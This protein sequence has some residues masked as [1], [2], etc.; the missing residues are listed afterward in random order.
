ML[1]SIATADSPRWCDPS[2]RRRASR[3]AGDRG[4]A[5]PAARVDA[6]RH[7]DGEGHDIDLEWIEGTG[8][9]GR[10]TKRDLL[11]FMERGGR[12]SERRGPPAD[13]PAPAALNQ[14]RSGH[15]TPTPLSHR[16]KAIAEHMTPS[17]ATAAHC[18]SFIEVDMTRVESGRRELGVTAL[19]VAAS[20]TID[21]LREHA[22]LN[23]WIEGD[24]CTLLRRSPRHRVSARRGRADRAGG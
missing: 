20:A 21:A 22:S 17:L 7:A 16:R 6:R 23:A 8:R 12:A 9:R 5:V 11:A 18:H 1:A 2:S 15:G 3:S 13:A 4:S 14:G 10:V 24:T 19:P